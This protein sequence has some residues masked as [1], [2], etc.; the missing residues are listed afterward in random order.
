ML[1][2]RKRMPCCE[3][4]FCFVAVDELAS[5]RVDEFGLIFNSWL[6]AL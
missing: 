3:R 6:M 2:Q 5:E 4:G 1:F